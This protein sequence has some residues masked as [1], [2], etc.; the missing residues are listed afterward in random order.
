MDAAYRSLKL[1]TA[2]QAIL[3][4]TTIARVTSAPWEWVTYLFGLEQQNQNLGALL[5]STTS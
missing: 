4:P 3:L 5:P 2:G 1:P